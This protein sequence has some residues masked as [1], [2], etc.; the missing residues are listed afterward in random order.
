MFIFFN[1]REPV[2]LSISDLTKSKPTTDHRVHR[3]RQCRI[4][5]LRKNIEQTVYG[6]ELGV[7][8]LC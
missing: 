3:L 4:G 7:E 8:P 5:A 6:K 2:Y 1:G